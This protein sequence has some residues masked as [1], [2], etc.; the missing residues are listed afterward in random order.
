[1]PR[2]MGEPENW[3]VEV[4]PQSAIW[5]GSGNRPQ[6]QVTCERIAAEIKRH[7]DDVAEARVMSDQSAICSHCGAKWTEESPDYNGGCCDADQSGAPEGE[8]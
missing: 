6:D 1:M 2:E 4:Y 5:I 3:R 8:D 7:V